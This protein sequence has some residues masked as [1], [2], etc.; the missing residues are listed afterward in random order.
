MR[1]PRRN[2][3]TGH[4]LGDIRAAGSSFLYG[5]IVGGDGFFGAFQDSPGIVPVFNLC[6]GFLDGTGGIF[7]LHPPDNAAAF[8]D[9]Q[10]IPDSGRGFAQDGF[11]TIENR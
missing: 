9:K 2:T 8:H 7:Q 4:F 3:G 11:C 10:V 1:Y 6:D 5:G